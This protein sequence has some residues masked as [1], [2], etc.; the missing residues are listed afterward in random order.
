[1]SRTFISRA[2]L[3]AAF[4]LM[5]AV[6]AQSQE[7]QLFTWMGR[8]DRDVRLTVQPGN[9]TNSAESSI[10]N[11]ARYR[12]G[13]ALPRQDGEIRVAINR[14]RGSASVLQQPNASNGYTAVVDIQDPQG[15]ADEYSV[16][17]Y[18][19][20]VSGRLYGDRR[21]DRE[22]RESGGDYIGNAP[23]IHWSGDVDTGVELVW[24]NGNL[25]QRM[26]RGGG[27]RNVSSSVS[28]AGMGNPNG[29]VNVNIRD[30]RGNVSVVQQPTAQNGYTTIIRITDPQGGYGHYTLDAYWR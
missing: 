6:P 12:M 18:W 16:T 29:V 15:G 24:R 20:P 7:V 26:M 1:M 17:A 25:T 8:V 10:N 2:V 14:G 30:G 13:S 22:R 19:Q 27:V 23:A 21:L 5:L 4:G 3:P 11:H 28:G 9:V